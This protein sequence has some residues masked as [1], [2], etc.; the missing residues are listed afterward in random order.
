MKF[1][2]APTGQYEQVNLAWYYDDSHMVK[3]GREIVDGPVCVVMGREERDQCRTIARPP[4]PGSW[5]RL[6][7][8]VSGNRIRA[9][10]GRREP[11]PGRRPAL[12][13][14]PAPA[15][16]RPR[17][18]LHSY[19]GVPNQEHWARI[20]EFTG[21]PALEVGFVAGRTCSNPLPCGDVGS[22]PPR[23]PPWPRRHV[24]GGERLRGGRPLRRPARRAR[25]PRR[26]AAVFDLG[27]RGR[28]CVL[29]PDRDR[30]LNGQVTNDVKALRVGDG[31]YAAVVT[32]KGRMESDVYIHRLAEE[33]LLDFEPGYSTALAGRLERYVIADDVQIV[34]VASHY[35]LLSVQ[36]P[37]AA[38][39]VA[40]LEWVGVAPRGAAELA[41]LAGA[42]AGGVSSR[43]PAPRWFAGVRTVCPND[44]A[45]RG[46]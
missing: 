28:L 25:R 10:T 8:T 11:P 31:C 1:E 2:N 9:S 12:C 40:T 14:L 13:H 20:T 26:S 3:L 42:G 7:L 15:G 30:F 23:V 46:G 45:G 36:G 5:Y 44:L 39:V 27:C 29:G 35:G 24:R 19:N 17:L 4:V 22:G 18:S 34:D 37:A 6:R 43:E 32:A 41:T 16:G 21:C 38:S 33:L